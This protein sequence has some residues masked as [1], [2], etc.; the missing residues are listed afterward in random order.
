LVAALCWALVWAFGSV[1][2]VHLRVLDD[3]S[4]RLERDPL[5]GLPSRSTFMLRANAALQA[6]ADDG[7]RVGLLVTD[8]DG[9]R[10]FNERLGSAAGDRLLV[11]FAMRLRAAAGPRQVAARLAGDEF[12]L[13]LPGLTG[14]DDLLLA[15][16]RLH[17]A[18]GGPIR[19]GHS[20]LPLSFGIGGAL[21][22]DDGGTVETLLDTA[23]Q[24][25]GRMKVLHARTRD[26]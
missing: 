8:I 20:L 19:V 16:E 6:A 15:A 17:A 18:A 3:F 26:V 23:R 22:P 5:T 25:M 11:A 9:L 1:V 4:D 24:A 13:L 21:H 2:L 7:T 12:A 14:R 10:W